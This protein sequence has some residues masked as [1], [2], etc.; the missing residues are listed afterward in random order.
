MEKKEYVKL[1]ISYESYFELYTPEQI[2][3]L[4]LAMMDYRKNGTKPEFTGYEKFVWPALKRDIDESLKAQE[5]AAQA[6]RDSGKMGGRPKNQNA[7]DKTD[8]NQNNQNGFDETKKRYRSK[9]KDK[10]K[11]QGKGQGNGQG[12]T[13]P[14]KSPQ[15]D[16]RPDDVFEGRSI[17]EPIK[18]EVRKWLEYK[19]ER[20]ETYKPTGLLSFLSTV[21][22]KCAM[23]GEEDIIDLIEESMSNGWRGIIWD[24][25]S[26]KEKSAEKP[27][28]L[29][30]DLL[31][32]KQQHEEAMKRFRA[33]E[34]NWE[35]LIP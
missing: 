31:E 30:P 1:W 35:D 13:I 32:A 17:P 25:L 29:P 18:A 27:K 8:E 5:A 2:G 22:K 3:H 20:R 33:G 9:D 24:H 12:Y 19:K 16:K 28:K 6:H 26:G 11:G 23:Y 15:G 14:P 34:A 21:E 7:F 10:G 4:V